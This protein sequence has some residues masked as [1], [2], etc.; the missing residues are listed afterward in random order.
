MR[1]KHY[2]PQKRKVFSNGG[3]VGIIV[4]VVVIAI[5]LTMTLLVYL[6]STEEIETDVPKIVGISYDENAIGVGSDLS[7]VYVTVTYSD[8]STENVAISNMVSEGLDVTVSGEQNVSL[9]FGGFEQTISVMVK[10]IDCNL[11]YT[12]STGG[13]IQGETSQSIV[14]G[15]D[16][17]S[18]I[19][20]PETGYE[21]VEWSDGYPYALRKDLKVNESKGYIAI[22]KKSEFRVIFFYND[23]TVASEEDVL[24]GE[25][26]TKAPMFTDPKM[27]VYGYTFVG[28]SVAEEDYSSVKRD[29]S[30]Y[31]QYVKTATDVNVSI[32]VDNKGSLMGETDAREEG[33][34][35]HDTLAAITA[36]PYPS[37]EF[38]S[39]FIR[40]SDGVYEELAKNE[41]R[42]IV[43][44]D[45]RVNVT[46]KSS[47]SGNSASEYIL[48]FTPNEEI[49]AIDVTAGFVYSS[50]GVTF[51]NYQNAKANNQE[52]F[53]D[54]I[55]YGTTLGEY[56]AEYVNGVDN[57]VVI[58]EITGIIRPADVVGM[59]FLGWY[60]QGDDTQ[61]LITKNMIF[62]QPTTLVA[63]W[64]KQ[65]YKIKFTYLDE[66]DV[67]QLHHTI[68]VVYQNTIGSGGGVPMNAPSKEKYLFIGWMDALTGD[69]IDD[70][71]QISLKEEYLQSEAFLT[72][73]EINVIAKWAPVEHVLSVNT[74]GAGTVYVTKSVPGGESSTEAVFGSYTIYETYDYTVSFSADE[75]NAVSEAR[76]DYS[77]VSEIYR[78]SEGVNMN[79]LT[80]TLQ[81]GYDNALSVVFVPQTFNVTV[82]NGTD[83]YSGYVTDNDDGITYDRALIEL[84]IDYGNTLT[85]NIHSYNEAFSIQKIL[86]TGRING[87]SYFNEVVADLKDSEMLEYALIL[88]NCVSDVVIDIVYSSRSYCVTVNKPDASEGSIFTTDFNGP[89]S[90]YT[91][92]ELQQEF[93]YGELQHYVITATE[94]KFISSVR[95]DGIKQ[96]VYKNAG[97]SLVFYDWEINGVYYGIGLKYLDDEYMYCYGTATVEGKTYMYCESL[98]GDN[99]YVYEVVDVNNE[100]YRRISSTDT[101]VAY[102]SVYASLVEQL[103]VNEKKLSNVTTGKDLRVTKVKVM[104]V[105]TKN[106]TLSATYEDI[107]YIVSVLDDERG[108]Y[109]IS[110][111][112][113]MGGESSSITITPING[114]YVAG[115]SVNG[116]EVVY[117]STIDRGATCNVRINDV[118]SDIEVR[119][120]YENL[121]YNVVFSNANAN[122]ADVT[123]DDGTGENVLSASYA[124]EVEYAS[125]KEY[126][127]RVADGYYISSVKIN[128]VTQP[129]VHLA[130]TY[131]YV[132]N[133]VISDAS[134]EVTCAL[135]A[136]QETVNGFRVDVS[137]DN[138]TDVVAGVNYGETTADDN[139]ITVIAD[140]GY[141]LNV[142]Y[143]KG[144]S[145]GYWRELV[146][147][148]QGDSVAVSDTLG[149]LDSS[150]IS[151]VSNANSYAKAIN[152]TLPSNAFDEVAVLYAV[153]NP[154]AYTLNVTSVGSG[155]VD[156]VETIYYGDIVAINANAL[157][158][159]YISAFRI[160]GKDVSFR[161]SNWTN[162][163]YA[164]VVNQY[165]GGT[166]SFI[167][168][169]NVDVY[170]EFSIYSYT[171]TLDPTSTNG[172]TILSVEG[173]SQELTKIKHGEYLNISMNADAGYHIKD[174][175]INGASVGYSSYSDVANDNTTDTFSLRSINAP[176]SRN[177]TVKVVYD[178]NR[179]ALNYEIENASLNF[180]GMDGAGTFSVPEYSQLNEKSYTGIA[181]G[182]NFYFEVYPSVGAGYYI[183]SVTIKYKGYGKSETI[184]TRYSDDSEGIVKREGG[185]IWFNRF[186]FGNNTDSATG[187]TADIELIKVTFKSNAYTLSFNQQGDQDGGKMAFA[188][189]NAN[190]SGAD[191]I[192]F[193][194]N[195]SLYYIRPSNGVVYEK[196]S[197]IFVATDIKFTNRNGK[198]T[199]YSESS[200]VEYN[201]NYEYGLRYVVTVKPTV[202]Y[203]RKVFIVNG[204]DKLSSVNNDK[205]STNVYRNTDVSVTYEILTFSIT[206]SSTVYNSSMNKIPA[207]RISEYMD[208][209]IYDVDT[210]EILLTTNGK[211]VDTISG[212]FDYGTKIKVVITPNFEKYGIYLYSFIVNNLQQGN[213][214]DTTGVVTYAKDGIALTDDISLRAIFRVKSY[215]IKVNT[216][217]NEKD[218]NGDL[219]KGETLNT[220][221]KDDATQATDWSVYWNESTVI[222]VV[223][224]EG[225]YV[226]SV[227]IKYTDNGEEREIKVNNYYLFEGE[228]GTIESG[229]V[230]SKNNDSAINGL[231]DIITIY[232]IT[233]EYKVTVV[234]GRNDYLAMYVINNPDFIENITTKFNDNN[235]V[236]PKKTAS[237]LDGR[238]KPWEVKVKSH[239]ELSVSI[240]PKDGYYI[241]IEEVIVESVIYNETTEEYEL[242]YDENGNA[243]VRTFELRDIGYG[244]G[245]MFSFYNANKGSLEYSISSDIR[246]Y[247]D[248]DIKEYTLS[249]SITRTDAALADKDNKNVTAVTLAVKDVNN[250]N[251]DVSG[252]IQRPVEYG[253]KD[254]PGVLVAEH[255]GTINYLFNVPYGYMLE[256]FVVNGFD[257]EELIG[258]GILNAAEKGMVSVGVGKAYNYDYTL[259][260]STTLINGSDTNPWVGNSD[261]NVSINIVPINYAIHVLINDTEHDFSV[262]NDRN[263]VSDGE[264]IIVYA[265]SVVS[266]F[267]S[268]TVEPSLYEGYQI[269]GTEIYFGTDNRHEGLVKTNFEVPVGGITA[270]TQYDFSTIN[271]IDT[272]VLTGLTHV[273]ILF[274]TKIL[275]YTQTIAAT[276]YYNDGTVLQKVPYQYESHVGTL[277]IFING[278]NING[279]DFPEDITPQPEG[280]VSNYTLKDREY[281]TQIRVEAQAVNKEDYALYGVYE[282]YEDYNGETVE[283]QVVSGQRGVILGVIN[284]VTTLTYTVNSF[285]ERKF[286]FEFKQK[287]TV[288]LNVE[289]PYKFVGGS[290]A[291]Y[292]SYTSVIAYEEGKII[293]A[294]IDSTSK[295]IDRYEYQ[296][297]VGNRLWF[298]Y[299]DAYKVTDTN[300]EGVKYYIIEDEYLDENDNPI[301]IKGISYFLN[302]IDIGATVSS[303]KSL[304]DT[305]DVLLKGAECT[306]VQDRNS[307]GYEIKSNTEFYLVTNVYGYSKVSVNTVGAAD[308]VDGGKVWYNGVVSESGVLNTS[309][310]SAGKLL[311]L[312][313]KPNDNYAFYQLKAR[314]VDFDSSRKNGVINFYN[315]SEIDNWQT[316]TVQDYKKA[317]ADANSTAAMEELIKAFN[318]NSSNDFQ[319]LRYVEDGENYYFIIYVM[320]NMEFEV[321]FYHT[322]DLDIGVY[323]TDVVS[324]AKSSGSGDGISHE[325]ISIRHVEDYVYDIAGF[326]YANNR[327]GSDGKV[328]DLSKAYAQLDGRTGIASYGATFELKVEKPMGNYQFV[329]WYVNDVNT[330]EY[331]ESLLPIADHL[332]QAL[333]INIDDM[334]ALLGEDKKE[335]NEIKIYAVFQPILDVTVL[336]QKY[337]AFDDHFNSWDMGE[338]IVNYY[339]YEDTHGI[340]GTPNTV[341]I[342]HDDSVGSTINDVK[343]RLEA[344]HAFENG[345]LS[346]NDKCWS[347]LH[348]DTVINGEFDENGNLVKAGYSDAMLN[349][350]KLYSSIF[351]FTILAQ[352]INDNNFIDNTWTSMKLG[353]NMS[354][355]PT[356]VEFS[357]W[358]YYNWNNGVWEN[359]TYWYPDKSFG[360]SEDGSYPVVDCYKESYDLDL[361]S[362]YDGCMPYAVSTS[363]S[364]NIDVDRPLLIRAD[365]YK[366]VTVKL[367]H[368]SYNTDLKGDI[369][370]RQLNADAKLEI[371]EV[372]PTDETYTDRTHNEGMSGTFEYGTTITITNDATN[373]DKGVFNADRTIRYRFL[374][375]YMKIED[376]V[377]YFNG[378]EDSKLANKYVLQLT[379]V[380]DTSVTDF[381]FMAYYVAQYKQTIYSY[382][383]G[384]GVDNAQSSGEGTPEITMTANAGEKITIKAINKLSSNKIDY[385]EPTSVV[386]YYHINSVRNSGNTKYPKVSADVNFTE[387]AY[388][389]EYYID[390]GLDYT[391]SVDTEGKGDNAIEL[392]EAKTST[393]KLFCPDFDTLYQFIHND[394]AVVNYSEYYNSGNGTYYIP[395]EGCVDAATLTTKATKAIGTIDNKNELSAQANEYYIKYVTTAVMVF[396]NFTYGGGISIRDRLAKMLTGNEN[397]SVLTVWDEDNTYGDWYKI[398]NNKQV[399]YEANGEVVIRLSL[400]DTAGGEELSQTFRFAY[401][402]MAVGGGEPSTPKLTNAGS[403]SLFKLDDTNYRRWEEYD[404]T[405]IEGYKMDVMLFGD[406]AY[407]EANSNHN[408]DHIGSKATNYLYCTD[409]T[410]SAEKG[411]KIYNKSQLAKIETF[412]NYNDKSCVGIIKPK[413]FKIDDPESGVGK[414]TFKLMTDLMLLESND[415]YTSKQD[416]PIKTEGYKPL[417]KSTSESE[418]FDGILDGNYHYLSGIGANNVKLDYFGLFEKIINGEVKNL[419]LDNTF[420][421][422]EVGKVGMLAGY[423]YN[424]KFTNIT[425]AQYTTNLYSNSGVFKGD[426]RISNGR[427]ICI[428]AGGEYA[429]SL[430][431]EIVNCIVDGITF[432]VGNGFTAEII[433]A[434]TGGAIFGKVTGGTVNNIT[435]TT[436]NGWLLVGVEET[437]QTVGGVFGTIDGGAVVS[438]V[439]VKGNIIIGN[440]STIYSG[441]VVGTMDGENTILQYV[442][443][444]VADNKNFEINI[445]P[446]VSTIGAS[447]SGLY[448]FANRTSKSDKETPTNKYG[449]V[450]GIVGSI[451]GAATLNNYNAEK[452]TFSTVKGSIRAYAGTVGGIVG[453]NN[454]MVTGFDLHTGTSSSSRFIVYVWIEGA[455][456]ES[457]N[458][459][460]VVG[461]NGGI[462]DDCSVTGHDTSAARSTTPTEW[463]SGHIYVFKRINYKDNAYFEIST[464]YTGSIPDYGSKYNVVMGGIVGLNTGSIFNSFVKDTRM[465][466]YVQLN[467]DSNAGSSSI[468]ATKF[469]TGVEAGLIAGYMFPDNEP[470]YGVQTIKDYI[471]KWDTDPSSENNTEKT[472]A[473]ILNLKGLT[474]S[475]IQSCY[476]SNSAIN[477]SGH[478]YMDAFTMKQDND[479]SYPSLALMGGILGGIGGNGINHQLTLNHCYS[480]NP[481]FVHYIKSYGST[482]ARE[483]GADSSTHAVGV[484]FR[485]YKTEK[486]WLGVSGEINEHWLNRVHYLCEVKMAYLVAKTNAVGSSV[487][488]S[489]YK[490]TT[491]TAV[492]NEEIAESYHLHVTSEEGWFELNGDWPATY[493]YRFVR[494]V[495]YSNAN[496]Y[497]NSQFSPNAIVA[498][499]ISTD[500]DPF[501]ITEQQ[502]MTGYYKGKLI[503]TNPYT[504]KL[505]ASLEDTRLL[506]KVGKMNPTGNKDETGKEI[507]EPEYIFPNYS[508]SKYGYVTEFVDSDYT[509]Y[510]L[511]RDYSAESITKNFVDAE[512]VT[513]MVRGQ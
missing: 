498:S 346:K 494:R 352:N 303:V 382:N 249:T 260:V 161:S 53:I 185:V 3:Y 114:Y 78:S 230:I 296:M 107:T 66:Y 67:T 497:S 27:N 470:Q 304:N 388:H 55:P 201:F 158:N 318:E 208:V 432:K 73:N 175:L 183:H 314:R 273:Y 342:A 74:L 362:L 488:V 321:E 479:D 132:N 317:M 170:V 481:I 366:T 124:Y 442:N 340:Y 110:K 88:E 86:V 154:S 451:L 252:Q 50:S 20:I 392:E 345:G 172:T 477:I 295:T 272:D 131:T 422:M 48:S 385:A 328:I 195:G 456:K 478:V 255:H 263:G 144:N 426:S 157:A 424:A 44:G 291:G 211:I 87:K 11:T 443:L 121:T 215:S 104:Y 227:I 117:V 360:Q 1:G 268:I 476:S 367:T 113:V 506:I 223:A 23:G 460:G 357:T 512:Q 237:A 51:I 389:F 206:L 184:V 234:F 298:E 109:L 159:Y 214:G 297:Y 404:L 335:V 191:V 405:N 203:S 231:R 309:A 412:W 282:I 419:R 4:A 501:I 331:L 34:Y 130:K 313:L 510:A 178:I 423:A 15:N 333:Y 95:V 499:E 364:S 387:K 288:V 60:V 447:E 453:A 99:V 163:T 81:N 467:A 409:N 240:E 468:I 277:D 98:L 142:V 275:T 10:D 72:D 123:V 160:N 236:Y 485:R 278:K 274:T 128:G 106:I 226:D 13:R 197:E 246:V 418:G 430:V 264:Q 368:Y 399:G 65:V 271:M 45:N 141:A 393:S 194:E 452:K 30:I 202:G 431:G 225:Y 8:G 229:L 372:E 14:S 49:A 292:K 402:G 122:V 168:C 188:I 279:E 323:R 101:S 200:D 410:G 504:G 302:G 32:S 472:T 70:R 379:C 492:M 25:K 269:T 355:M 36:T 374:G 190:V 312:E 92:P 373:P 37:R 420:M 221:C 266:H 411:Y 152:V 150:I 416:L 210:D 54:G 91:I 458:V 315:A 376:D 89:E 64:T 137:K 155:N 391:L 276:V 35:A 127:L 18:V 334:P 461:A 473:N 118:R 217:Y 138:V 406:P 173:S 171:V 116:G 68:N 433:N 436:D 320:G 483:G 102:G 396:Y 205:Y 439:T 417:C 293:N 235:S 77:D 257:R 457:I 351:D 435:L 513:F 449:K 265:G 338:V 42:I 22:F 153:G 463:D 319:I 306:D 429:G 207:A 75:G 164:S 76:W 316:F 287:V 380:S 16:A 361:I 500:F 383:V 289:N 146:F 19:A 484:G 400:V 97:T 33:Y 454:G 105:A 444:E 112:N 58:D 21:F 384:Y 301:P 85:F 496:S 307:D 56:L 353:L 359:I 93:N 329:G 395:D 344:S 17:D 108:S 267:G 145:G 482:S 347:V 375:W 62:G 281:F 332:A 43:I 218:D 285:G 465:T 337:Y 151:T 446:T 111:A 459:G 126:V 397:I 179:Y 503:R 24:Y 464:G 177:V 437:N 486:G 356:D 199:F 192:V 466:K 115:Y 129:I 493:N 212:V 196:Q 148:V 310:M 120:V 475:R 386:K 495:T 469:A 258:K 480:T 441:G 438:N 371:V 508:D 136:I 299:K 176:A 381:E 448:L 139:V 256:S 343:N 245:K 69:M 241:S 261:I 243:L 401:A 166:Y 149:I 462:V 162:L 63:K 80:V 31:P 239:D 9:S 238:D 29:M 193:D 363:D 407:S 133:N 135:I 100:D 90:G 94:G 96:D 502:S 455:S 57:T 248:V 450:G 489:Y 187:V 143:L 40:N 140:D 84:V 204:E 509:I 325:G 147:T 286:K 474:I 354:G 232:G 491:P 198:W 59:T 71:T 12:A 222:K 79:V 182:D 305:L 169:E 290:N 233:S 26:A 280:E 413:E 189:N 82:N 125:S 341:R 421:R 339:P 7:R 47:A 378:S 322:Y 398:E 28:W 403:T 408:K 284:G 5:A 428:D 511:Y 414:T 181:H 358:Q 103:K 434:T 348:N 220:V 490:E 209:T 39:W 41:E 251:L 369:S 440:E 219:I 425:I 167:A 180:K 254:T 247:I 165:V 505:N 394:T 244:E 134:I 2:D 327:I 350:S 294:D 253:P 83:V 216:S 156:A 262:Y 507:F 445:T 300:Q 52:Y 61:T 174:V 6:P 250:N 283:A 38:N 326:T 365:V 471:N 224:G 242:M 228:Y 186:M 259:T 415:Y 349:A 308:D 487:G 390:A 270:R 370:E 311:K 336:N 213:L 377:Y 119:I 330:F 427:R 46:F 324:V